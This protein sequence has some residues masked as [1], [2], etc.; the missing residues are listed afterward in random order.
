MKLSRRFTAADTVVD[1]VREDYNILP[2]LSRFSLPL[3][4][5]PATVGELCERCGISTDVFLLIVNFLLSGEIDGDKM[6][7]VPVTGVVDFLHNSHDYFL[8]YKFPH[9]RANLLGA[10]DDS[11]TDIN[12]II[13]RFFDDF[14]HHVEEHF[15][16]EERTVFPHVRAIAAGTPSDYSIA[17]FTRQHDDEISRTLRE[18]KNIILRY[19]DTSRPYRMY[20]VLVDICNVEDDLESHNVIENNILVPL[21]RDE[22]KRRHKGAA[23]R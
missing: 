4:F 9:I 7:A 18:L 6:R 12:P 16:Y 2:V 17:T 21:A 3:G 11:H 13:V 1:L 20:D 10:L 19:Y 23:G 15:R 5:G 8:A 14:V 22:E